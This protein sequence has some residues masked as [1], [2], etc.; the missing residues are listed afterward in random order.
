MIATSREEARCGNWEQGTAMNEPQPSQEL[1]FP[2]LL[3]GKPG[4]PKAHR[5]GAAC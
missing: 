3:I 1:Q 4:Y 5:M 2:A